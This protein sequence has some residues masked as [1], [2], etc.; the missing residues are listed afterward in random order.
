VYTFRLNEV[1]R[2][3]DLIVEGALRSIALTAVTA[4]LGLLVGTAC[5]LVLVYGRRR[6]H[7]VV[8]AYVELFRNTPFLVQ[9]FVIFFGLASGGLRLSATVAAI[10][11]LTLNFGAYTTEIVRAGIQSV[12]KGQL[13]SAVSLG[14]GPRD[15]FFSVI[16]FQAF[17]SV[18][19][20]LVSYV[21]L[22]FLGTSV[23]SQISADD[24]MRAGSFID[25]RTFRSFEVYTVI[26]LVYL[27][28]VLM[29]RAAGALG[30]TLFFRRRG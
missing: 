19:R 28:I 6:W 11:A 20:S 10:L 17:R 30:W 13:E 15:T 2:Y 26:S 16:V 3:S 22:L 14:L 5:A 8:L 25:S 7:V 23:V 24:L 29:M 21:V 27:A 18:Y 1:L 9:L 4:L 12:P